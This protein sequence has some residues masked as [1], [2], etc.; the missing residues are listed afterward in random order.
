MADLTSATGCHGLGRVDC[1]GGTDEH[2]DGGEIEA[3]ESAARQR[4]I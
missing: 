1:R 3:D 2:T 4:A